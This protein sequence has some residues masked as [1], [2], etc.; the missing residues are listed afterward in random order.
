MRW[1]IGDI[2]GMLQPLATL[3]L[4]ARQRDPQA[5]FLFVGDYVNRGPDSRNVIDLLLALKSEGAARFAR[6]NHDDVFDLLL[7]ARCYADEVAA[8]DPL[9]AFAWFMQFGLAN[10]LNSYGIDYSELLNLESRP[11]LA[12]LRSILNSVPEEHRQFI[13]NLE[14]VIDEPDLFVAHAMWDVAESTDAS[15]MAAHLAAHKAARHTLLWG[16]YKKADLARPKWWTR[17]GFFGHTPISNYTGSRSTRNVPVV[18]PSIVLL[19]TAAALGAHGRL[20]A[21]CAETREFL[22]ADPSGRLLKPEPA[23]EAKA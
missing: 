5:R 10:T 19:D 8:T 16:R 21:Y 14:P 3:L 13:R 6:G 15:D 2:H 9:A 12:K 23:V 20:T 22:Q 11:T 18:G 7:N 1:I 4:T 17:S